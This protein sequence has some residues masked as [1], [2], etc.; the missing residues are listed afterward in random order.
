MQIINV[1]LITLSWKILF[2]FEFFSVRTFTF[3]LGEIF[4]SIQVSGWNYYIQREFIF[5]FTKLTTLFV[6][7]ACRKL[8]LPSG[9]VLSSAHFYQAAIE[10][11]ATTPPWPELHAWI[12]KKVYTIQM[13]SNGPS[14]GKQWLSDWVTRFAHRRRH[15]WELDPSEETEVPWVVTQISTASTIAARAVNKQSRRL[16]CLLLTQGE[17]IFTFLLKALRY[18]LWIPWSDS[19]GHQLNKIQG[20]NGFLFLKEKSTRKKLWWSQKVRN[21]ICCNDWARL[22]RNK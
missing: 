11:Q 22:L 6:L 18:C 1:L 15:N 3:L 5:C 13:H 19:W 9:D 16:V 8:R 12:Y 7:A 21:A 10:I 2:I 4:S 14:I 20:Q 17:K